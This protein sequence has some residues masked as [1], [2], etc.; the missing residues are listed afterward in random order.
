MLI[1]YVEQ[2][3]ILKWFVELD[4]NMLLDFGLEMLEVCDFD[5]EGLLEFLNWMEFCI[6]IN[7]VVECFGIELLFVVEVVVVVVESKVDLFVIDWFGYEIIC[8]EVVLS[9]WLVEIIEKGQVVIDIE[10]IG[11]DEMQVDLVGVLL[12]MGLGWVVYLLLGYVSE[13]VVGDLFGVFVWLDGQMEMVCVLVLLKLVL[14]DVVILKIGQNIKYDWKIFVWYGICMV[15]V[16]DMMLMFYVLNVGD[17]NYGMDEFVDCYLGYCCILIK[18]LIGLGKL[19]IGFVEVL[20][21]KVGEYVVEDVEVIWWLWYYFC[22]L[23][24]KNCVMI[25]YQLLEWLMVVVLVDM[26]MMGICI[27][28]DY[29]KC[30]FSVF[31][32]KMVVLEVEIY[33][34]VGGFFNVGSF[35]QLGE[36]LFECMG[37]QGGKQG[38]IGVFLISVDVLEDLVVEGYDLFVWVLDWWVIFKLKLIYIDVLLQ[39]V[40]FEIGCVY[41]SYLIIGVQIGCLVL[42]D[43]NLQNILV[44]IEE[45]WCIW[46]VFVVGLRMW[47]VSLDYSQIELWILVY[48]VQILVLKQVFCDGIDIY[49]M[50][51]SQMF[52]VLIEGMDLMICC[53]VKVI[54]FGVIYGILG[55]GLVCNLCILWVEVQVFID[56]YFE[57]FLE[58]CVYMD[59]IVVEVK[60]DG[61]V[62]MLF[63]WWIMMLGIN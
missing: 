2:I 55:F 45:G 30:M 60:Q 50:I 37:L 49:V 48:V 47:L 25:V 29:F 13:G 31:V 8:D 34:L 61:Y 33:E 43:L 62:C 14:E 41:I 20:I 10:I 42:I 38:K 58:I 12:C 32:Q 51:V 40:N 4:C 27:D 35:K 52:G 6:L 15:L 57:C 46:Q 9:L 54:N 21:V 24:L 3:C 16:E 1:D 53:C 36:I 59:C 39:Y 11:L 28:V 56:I 19:Q 5:F 44:W 26:E 18:D 7:C 23:L 17:Y 63:G 22:L